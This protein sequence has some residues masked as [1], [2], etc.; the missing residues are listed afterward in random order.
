MASELSKADLAVAQVL[1]AIQADGRKA[2]LLGRGTASFEA[3]TEAYAEARNLD[4]GQY[5]DEF[6]ATC[7]PERVFVA[8]GR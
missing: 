7:Q 2:Y 4:V 5:R 3:L 6:W 1:R 8:E